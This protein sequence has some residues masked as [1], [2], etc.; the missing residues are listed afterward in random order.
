MLLVSAHRPVPRLSCTQLPRT[1]APWT[2]Q[3]LTPPVQPQP[4]RL[5]SQS[6][7]LLP[8]ISLPSTTR[9]WMT[10]SPLYAFMPYWPL[11]RRQLA[12][13]SCRSPAISPAPELFWIVACSITHP[14]AESWLTTPSS[15][16]AAKS[17]TVTWLR[18]TSRAV[19]PNAYWL[20]PRPSSTAPG[21]P[22]YRFPSLG[23]TCEKRSDSSRCL[24]GMSQKVVCAGLL[25]VLAARS[26]TTSGSTLTAPSGARSGPGS[27]FAHT[28]AADCAP[29]EEEDA[30][31]LGAGPSSGV[32]SQPVA[33]SA[34]ARAS[35]AGTEAGR[36]R[37]RQVVPMCPPPS[38]FLVFSTGRET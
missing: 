13:T 32:P 27:G 28:R 31:G 8:V 36:S 33:S 7:V 26:P 14:S 38:L 35:T 2:A 15:C 24:P 23:T 18:V 1:S 9:S 5:R 11:P 29:D 22:T 16:G 30:E 21:A 3:N 10:P 4:G 37:P 34:S 12:R 6:P 25:R 17:C 20:V 19:P